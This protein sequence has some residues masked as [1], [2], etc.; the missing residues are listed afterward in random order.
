MTMSDQLAS[1]LQDVRLKNAQR[2]NQVRVVGAGA[3]F[4]TMLVLIFG[5]GESSWNYVLKPV[6][7]YFLMALVFSFGSRFSPK[8]LWM[9][10]FA[11]PAFDMPMVFIIQYINLT[12]SENAGN[13][14]E[15]S[16]SL[17]VCLLML[18]AYT[19][20][21]RHIIVSMILA[22]VFEQILQAS[23]GIETGG[24]AFSTVVFGLATWICV[25]A[26]KNRLQLVETVVQANIRRLRLQRYFSPGV[27][28]L[29]EEQEAETLAQGKDCEL[30]IVFIDI[31]GFTSLSETLPTREVV[32]LLNAYHAYMVEAIFRYGGTLDKYL[33]DGLITYFNAPVDQPD[34]AERAVSCAFEME[35]KLVTFNEER[36]KEG[37]VPIRMGIGIHTGP[38]IVGD[39]GAPH[40]RE[41]TAIGSAVNVTARL[42]G[43]T[44]EVDR[45]IVVSESTARLVPDVNWDELGQ[46]PIRGCAEPLLLFAPKA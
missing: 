22:I 2:I 29:L 31:R 10:R 35:Q 44:K 18:S 34:H 19:L 32:E 43:M 3:F 24:R 39:I 11:V 1:A 40:R 9:S 38:A 27:G 26:G 4:V 15:F 8:I 36:S 6:A 13:V 21:A 23:A 20:N 12:K 28:E 25:F 33:G 46:Y 37:K 41:F 16:V 42:E 17:F 45:S 7:I 5:E 30:T 14:S